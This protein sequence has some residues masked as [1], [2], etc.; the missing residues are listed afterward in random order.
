MPLKWVGT[1]KSAAAIV[2]F[3]PDHE[4]VV[5]HEKRRR[6]ETGVYAERPVCMK[7]DRCVCG[8][9]NVYEKRPVCMKRD[10]CV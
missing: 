1:G 10:Q 7:R 8:E 9:T 6:K 3:L 4:K 2:R 5:I